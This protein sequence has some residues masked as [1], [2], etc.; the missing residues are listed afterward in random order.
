MAEITYNNITAPRTS[1]FKGKLPKLPKGSLNGF[2]KPKPK[3]I[4]VSSTPEDSYVT[5]GLEKLGEFD[6]TRVTV[7]STIV[8]PIPS[9]KTPPLT[10]IISKYHLIKQL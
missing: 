10:K 8:V 6:V 4:Y 3:R 2:L 1:V 9:R 5:S 7:P